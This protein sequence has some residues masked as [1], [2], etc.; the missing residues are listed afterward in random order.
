MPVLCDETEETL[1]VWPNQTP[2]RHC[3]FRKG[4]RHGWDRM[5][6][7]EGVLVDEAFYVEGKPEGIHSR[8]TKDGELIEQFEYVSSEESVC[9]KL[10][11]PKKEIATPAFIKKTPQENRFLKLW[12]LSLNQSAP[13]L[14]EEVPPKLDLSKTEQL[15]CFGVG[16]FSIYFEI[17]DWLGLSPRHRLFLI[18][19]D[20]TA[21]FQSEKPKK[22]LEDPQVFL[23]RVE[24]CLELSERFPEQAIQ[25]IRSSVFPKA[26]FEETHEKLL[27]KATLSYALHIDRLHSEQLFSNFLHNLKEIP[28]A[29]YANHLR[30]KLKN[31]PAIVC[32]AGPSLQKAIPHLKKLQESC[33]IIAGGS[34][35]AA[36]SSQGIQPHL[37]MAIDPNLEEYRRLCQS[38]AFHTPLL[39]STRVFPSIF[40]T[41]QGPFGYMRSGI[42]GALELWIEEELQLTEPLLGQNLPEEA[43]SVT[44]ISLALAQEM[45][46]NPIYLSGVDL[47]YTDQ[48]RYAAGV[49]AQER[50]DQELKEKVEVSEKLTQT[51]SG[52]G[53]PI[54]TATRWVMEARAI[55]DFA[56]AHPEVQWFN[57]S[58]E[59][60]EIEG[61][62]YIPLEEIQKSSTGISSALQKAIEEAKMPSST[63]EVL[64]TC[65]EALFASLERVIKH[66][67]ILSERKSPLDELELK[68]EMAYAYLFYDT[69]SVLSKEL[70]LDFPDKA[71][72]QEIWKRF[73]QLALGYARYTNYK[74]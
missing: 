50:V 11:I 36:L 59:G 31:K 19:A 9:K 24:D 67:R 10:S 5:W 18:D 42:G 7:E 27:S 8:W 41:M 1:L 45:G 72:E 64:L 70:S 32:G 46:C 57:T 63:K 47:A 14:K 43:L 20:F 73:L 35:L 69:L 13:A 52:E 38:F 22:L 40:Q 58:Q 2:K 62:S 6:S 49:G 51:H 28:R 23:E 16:L 65:T 53:K 29:F 60:L 4:K 34:T 12:L 44:M 26:L 39:F 55:R 17:Q 25:C 54:W 15:Y 66:L 37:G 30:E 3:F 68:E 56:K 48:K 71:P 21:F 61:V 33:C 74:E